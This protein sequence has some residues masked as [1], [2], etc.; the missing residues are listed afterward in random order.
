MATHADIPAIAG[1]L[2]ELFSQEAEFTPDAAAQARGLSM[3]LDQ[4]SAAGIF[5]AEADGRV[6][7]SVTLLYSVSTALG[8]RIAML[9][10]MIITRTFRGHG[11]GPRLL[12]FAIEAARRDGIARITLLT[13][14]DNFAAHRLYERMGFHRSAMVVYRKMM[15]RSLTV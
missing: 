15:P 1:L 9:E 12:T 8:A 14:P 5:V 11:L 6:I 2:G 3:L 10:D 13:D 7:G 4:P